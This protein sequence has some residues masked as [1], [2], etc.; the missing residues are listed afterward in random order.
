MR[1]AE[2]EAAG[3]LIQFFDFLS[4]ERT[5]YRES[6]YIFSVCVISQRK[7]IMID[8]QGVCPCS[9][10]TCLPDLPPQLASLSWIV[11]INRKAFIGY[12]RV[13]LSLSIYFLFFL[14]GLG[15]F[16][17][18]TLSLLPGKLVYRRS[19]H[20]RHSLLTLTFVYHSWSFE[21]E[22]H[23]LSF[24]VFRHVFVISAHKNSAI[25]NGGQN[26]KVITNVG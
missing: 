24:P 17:V 11:Y 8:L 21:R 1:R 3:A 13:L 19:L 26:S 14:V 12:S 9:I 16:F 15:Q 5:D 25:L 6:L 4:E 20:F 22:P 7:T 10:Q 23:K 2:T 18:V